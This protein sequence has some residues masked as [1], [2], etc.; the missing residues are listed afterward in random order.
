MTKN[1][2][3]GLVLSLIWISGCA[4]KTESSNMSQPEKPM[5][6]QDR[7]DTLEKATITCTRMGLSAGT[8]AFDACVLKSL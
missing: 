7:A 6:N 8:K 3:Y 5:S 4:N 2:F 1:F